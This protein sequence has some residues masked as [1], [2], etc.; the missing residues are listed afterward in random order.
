MSRILTATLCTL[1]LCAGAASAQTMSPMGNTM[2][3]GGMSSPS[4]TSTP[5][6]TKKTSSTTPGTMA[7]N[8]MSAGSMGQGNMAP[9]STMKP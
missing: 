2:S 1:L 5:P 3:P 9:A 6:K 7:P 4:H 8:G